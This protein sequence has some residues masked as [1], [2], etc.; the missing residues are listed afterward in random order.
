VI[1]GAHP[2]VS[3]LAT[4]RV[5]ITIEEVRALVSFSYFSPSQAPYRVV[6]IEDADRMTDRT[7]NVLLKA[8][9]EPPPQTVWI[10]CAPSP[11]DVLPTIR[12]RMRSVNLVVPTVDDVARLISQREG[13]DEDLARMA[14][15]ESQNHIGMAT[16]LATDP[17]ARARRDASIRAVLNVSSVSGAVK[18]A[19]EL[20]ELSKSDAMALVD[21]LDAKERESAPPFA[22]GSAGW[23][24]PCRHSLPREIDGGRQKR[25]ATRSLRDAVDRVLVDVMSLLR[26]VLMIQVGADVGL[27]NVKHQDLLSERATGTTAE[28]TMSSLD[29]IDQ[30]RARMAQNS[31]PL[32]VL[33]ALLIELSGKAAVV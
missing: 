5:T 4:D 25:R 6:V 30:A 32:L 7:S 12:S 11:A 29:A 9:E 28:L 15:T 16:R 8:L 21:R 22:G 10:L 26:D 20:L 1:A 14:A 31:P 18:T 3:I 27:I 23:R 24:S 33:E 13:V 17:E 2:D 19:A